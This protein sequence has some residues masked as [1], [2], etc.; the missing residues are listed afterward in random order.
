VKK[1]VLALGAALVLSVVTAPAALAQDTSPSCD[2]AKKVVVDLQA[3]IDDT[4]AKEH[5]KELADL[6]AAKDARGAA[7]AEVE[8]LERLIK[9]ATDPVEIDRLNGLLA[10]AKDALVARRTDVDKAQ[11]RLDR[12]SDRLVGLR[13]RLTAAITERDRVCGGV[14]T[15]PTTPPADNDV[16]CG[17]VTDTEAQRILDA[18]KSDPNRLDVDGDGIAC[19]DEFTLNPPTNDVV[20]TPSGGVATGGGPA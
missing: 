13:T 3:D 7:K 15:T 1:T 19:E 9:E 18:D 10:P 17:E 8:R 2:E 12:E 11:E 6:A 14:T 16:D 20:V 5:V 4:A